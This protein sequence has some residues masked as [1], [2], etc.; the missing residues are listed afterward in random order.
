MS[1]LEEKAIQAMR[2]ELLDC[3]LAKLSAHFHDTAPRCKGGNEV[4]LFEDMARADALAYAVVRVST[5]LGCTIFGGFLAAHFSGKVW[6]DIDIML[7]SQLSMHTVHVALARMLPDIIDVHRSEVRTAIEQRGAYGTRM[8]V[9]LLD[10]HDEKDTS[11]SIDL[12]HPKPR[13]MYVPTT[14]GSCLSYDGNEMTIRRDASPHLRFWRLSD[15]LDI[16]KNG[17]DV[18]L[19]RD[20]GGSDDAYQTWFWQRIDKL[21]SRGYDIRRRPIGT[22]VPRPKSRTGTAASA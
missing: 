15:V 8:Q 12:V 20:H 19:G 7:P 1:R 21:V 22:R 16:L 3:P 5:A 9:T 6:K 10:T 11:V 2:A 17:E 13:M 4:E 18:M 14:I